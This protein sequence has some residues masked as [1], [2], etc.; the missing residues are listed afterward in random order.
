MNVKHCRNLGLLAMALCDHGKRSSGTD[1]TAAFPMPQQN[2][3]Q[4][5][6]GHC[7]ALRSC[8]VLGSCRVVIVALGTAY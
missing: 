4:F 2:C 1:L 3:N 7:I 6:K 8:V 5:P